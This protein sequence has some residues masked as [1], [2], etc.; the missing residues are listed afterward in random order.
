M[1]EGRTNRQGGQSGPFLSRRLTL[2][3]AMATGL[4]MP[5]LAQAQNK[6]VTIALTADAVILDPHA[7]N[8]LTG[9]I[10]FYHF[11]DAL[12]TR[13]P[14]LE[15]KPGLAESWQIVD[16]TTWVFKLRQGVKFHNGDEL[17]ASDVVYT[18]ERLKKAL[19]ASFVANIASA[20]AIDDY[21]VEFKTP[22]PFAV[23]HMALAEV[24]IVNEKHTKA[25][26]DE[27][28]GLKPMGTGPYKLAQ[29][30]KEDRIEMEAFADYWRGKPKIDRVI[31]KPITNPATRTAALLTG[32]VDVIQD[33]SVRDVAGVQ[34]NPNFKVVTR[35]SLL[36]LVIALDT[37]DKS[38]TIDLP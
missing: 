34:A 33:L 32:G 14:E 15:F 10:M 1:T 11:Y 23:L 29:W 13:T 3:L 31:F 21:T 8:E 27:Q 20:R 17:K 36:N 37:R 5:G 26:G 38:P 24:L 30:I 2:A 6:S 16:D 18:V 28:M 19:M 7:A 25:I 22:K 35:P 4:A 12:V 9:N